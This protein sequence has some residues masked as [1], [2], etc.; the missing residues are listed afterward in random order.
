MPEAPDGEIHPV[1]AS[2]AVPN[3]GRPPEALEMARA[4]PLTGAWAAAT[5]FDQLAEVSAADELTSTG[6]ILLTFQVADGRPFSFVPGQFVTILAGSGPG[7]HQSPYA[8][9]TPPEGTS[10]FGVLVKV[11]PDG[12]VATYLGSLQRGDVISFRGPLGRSMLPP[13]DTRD[14]ALW[15]TGVGV[16]PFLGLVELLVRQGFKRRIQLA[17][18]LRHVEDVCLVDELDGLAAAHPTFAYDLSLSDPDEQWTGRRG[19]ITQWAPTLI[20]DIDR[21]RF[22]LCGNGAMVEEMAAG[23]SEVGV[24]SERIYGEPYF[25]RYHR[26]DPDAVHR[27]AERF[28]RHRPLLPGTATD[29]PFPVSAPLNSQGRGTPGRPRAPSS[30]ASFRV[31]DDRG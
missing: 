24:T 16:G 27:V 2:T 30:P 26:A 14:L 10:R 25:K 29:E 20:D 6:T 19:R 31:R 15:A 18:G 17:W 12:P 23:L 7:A 1:A 13:D 5:A 9:C 11:V 21:F 22:Y 4:D 28:R 8:I 3:R